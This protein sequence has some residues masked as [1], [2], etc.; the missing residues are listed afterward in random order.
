MHIKYINLLVYRDGNT[1]IHVPVDND[2][3][4]KIIE[5]YKCLDKEIKKEVK[6]MLELTVTD[7]KTRKKIEIGNFRVGI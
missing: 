6:N 2:I 3:V 1:E 7:E 5:K 4:E